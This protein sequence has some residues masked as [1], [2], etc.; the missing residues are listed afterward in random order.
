MTTFRLPTYV[1]F[2]ITIHAYDKVLPSTILDEGAS[3]SLMSSTTWQ[4]V[5]SPQLVLVTHN[6]LAFD[7]G[8]CQPIGVLPNLPIT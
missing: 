3:V 2:E 6:M 7:G 5:G 8:S 4:D 1:A